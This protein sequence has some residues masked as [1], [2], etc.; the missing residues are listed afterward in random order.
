MQTHRATMKMYHYVKGAKVQ[1][2]RIDCMLTECYVNLTRY[3]FD[4]MEHKRYKTICTN[5]LLNN[6]GQ[7]NRV[8]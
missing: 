6:D 5:F 3:L 2:P 8:K 7:K 4:E 1:V